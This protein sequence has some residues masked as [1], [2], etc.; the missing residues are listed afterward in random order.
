ML[1]CIVKCTQKASYILQGSS[2]YDEFVQQAKT[3]LPIIDYERPTC[4]APTMLQQKRPT[5]PNAPEQLIATTNDC[6]KH[7]SKALTLEFPGKDLWALEDPDLCFAI[8]QTASYENCPHL[9]TS[10]RNDRMSWLED[11]SAKLAPLSN[12]LLA[13][14]EPHAAHLNKNRPL[15][16]ICGLCDAMPHGDSSLGLEIISGMQI[17]GDIPD[18]H[19]HKPKERRAD[20]PWPSDFKADNQKLQWQTLRSGK[21]ATGQRK[22]DLQETFDATM[23]EVDG[24]WTEGPFTYDQME[25]RFGEGKWWACLRFPHRRTPDA[26]VRPCDNSKPRHN[27]VSSLQET[28]SC[29]NS[30]FPARV[31]SMFYDLLGAVEMKVGTDDWKKAY[32][33]IA[34][35]QLHLNVVALYDPKSKKVWYFVVR[36]HC[37]GMISSVNNFNR[38]PK[39]TAA[40]LRRLFFC[41]TAPYYDDACHVSPTFAA[42]SCQSMHVK[43]HSLLGFLLEMDKQELMALVRP[44]L[45]VVTD[46]TS[47]SKGFFVQ[48]VLP[49]RVIN[50]KSAIAAFREQKALTNSDAS[51]LRAKMFFSMTSGFGRIGRAGLFALTKRQY[52]LSHNT[53]LTPDILSCFD[54]CEALLRCMPAR[55]YYLK[56]FK[57]SPLLIWS[58]ASYELG[59]GLLGFVVYDPDTTRWYFSYAQVPRSY[60]AILQPKKQHIHEFEVVAAPLTYITLLEKSQVSLKDREVIHFIDNFG[61]MSNLLKG[62]SK[63]ANANLFISPFHIFNAGIRAHIWWQWVETKSNI[64]DFPSRLDFH[65]LYQVIPHNSTYLP[66]SMP[67]AEDWLKGV[68]FWLAKGGCYPPQPK[69][70]RTR[71]SAQ[72]AASRRVR[73]RAS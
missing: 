35:A 73:K 32:R 20:M 72:R 28:I 42:A 38:V 59:I 6:I 65:A 61:A 25:Q 51:T 30:E 39:F 37:F 45:G 23:K 5:M 33:Q 56:N 13:L 69:P 34:N 44:F 46:F 1:D 67:P 3:L 26:P 63:N 58:D 62:R 70:K 52:S 22:R 24:G 9:L 60:F 41:P 40:I 16:V 4:L 15:A 12:E 36:G 57:R 66:M 49:R 17:V 2:L 64:A 19:A 10:L 54:F 68:D 43:L 53:S 7:I 50:I 14:C 47:I 27:R 71:S 55:H 21:K 18:S 31:Q 11:W 48:R 29:E 8:Q